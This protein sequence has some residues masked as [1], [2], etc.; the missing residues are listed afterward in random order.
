M[1]HVNLSSPISL[2]LICLSLFRVRTD[3]VWVLKQTRIRIGISADRID[4]AQ[5]TLETEMK[6]QQKLSRTKLTESTMLR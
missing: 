5:G 2:L 4:L 6:G 1:F 3:I